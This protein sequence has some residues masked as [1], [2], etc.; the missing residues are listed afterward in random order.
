MYE[1]VLLNSTDEFM[2][3]KGGEGKVIYSPPFWDIKIGTPSQKIID[4]SSQAIT[5]EEEQHLFAFDRGSS[6]E[7]TD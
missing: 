4:F 6:I 1:F 3:K 7:N 2:I 5:Q